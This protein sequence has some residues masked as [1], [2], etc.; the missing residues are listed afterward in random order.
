MRI[1]DC[2]ELECIDLATDGRGIG[3]CDGKVVFVEGLLPGE[4]AMVRILAQKRTVF[5]GRVERRLQESPARRTPPCPYFGRCGGCDL[6]H[7]AEEMQREFKRKRVGDCFSRLCGM[8]VS[9]SPVQSVPP[10]LRYRNKASFPVRTKSGQAAV[11]Y[12]EKKNGRLVPVAACALI[13]PSMNVLLRAFRTWLR[14]SGVR[15]YDPRTHKGVVRRFAMRRTVGGDLLAE[16]EINAKILPAREMLVECLTAAAPRLCGICVGINEAR[17]ADNQAAHVRGIYG[18]K[19]I[20]ETINGLEFEVSMQSFLQVNAAAAAL[21]YETA[22]DLLDIRPGERVA[23][24]YCGV[25]TI[26]LQAAQRGAEVFGIEVVPQAIA[27]AKRNA[28]RNGIAQVEFLCAD[29]G[30]GFRQLAQRGISLDAVILDPPRKGSAPEV[31]GQI[32]AAAPRRVLYISCDPATL[33]RDVKQFAAAGYLPKAVQPVDLFP[34]TSHIETI[35]LLERK[36]IDG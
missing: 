6:L 34:Q 14:Q 11:G 19:R 35:C 30:E 23:D 10:A 22:L 3:K 26:T 12:L 32:C 27:D 15:A 7:A 16:V 18:K 9:V 4:R 5:E 33:A 21:L 29:A 8:Q 25:G 36:E 2:C 31:I 13:D 20:V 17:G 24:L 1:G 28:R